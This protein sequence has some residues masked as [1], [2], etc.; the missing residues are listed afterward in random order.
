MSGN[1]D[2]TRGDRAA[3][4]S[5]SAG[6]CYWPGCPEPIVREVEGTYKIALAIAH[7][8]ALKATGE[9]YDPRM[10][11]AERDAFEN[12]IFLCHPHHQVI[13]ESGAAK[14]W[15]AEP[16]RQWKEIRE[17][18]GI[19]QLRDL[20]HLTEDRLAEI[21]NQAIA[22]RED[23]IK[24]TLIR[25]EQSDAEAAALLKELRVE[26]H[27]ARTASSPVN[28]DAA[29]LLYHAARNLSHLGDSAEVLNSAAGKL[30]G[31]EDN[32]NT[33]RNAAE[34]IRRAVQSMGDYR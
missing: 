9:R 11:D 20:R 22:A 5:L 13:D 18:G 31:L 7:I 6:T 8:C 15:P 12:L 32:A 3:L 21:I 17:R 24:H 30:V 33:L 26:L 28:L 19:Q 2:Y 29:E 14:K 25:L 23:E 10:T 27:A 16:L 4:I 1:R 34:D